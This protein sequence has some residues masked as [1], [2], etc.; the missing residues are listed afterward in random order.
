[1]VETHDPEAKPQYPPEFLAAIQPG[2]TLRINYGPEARPGKNTLR[3]VRGIVDDIVV[4]YRT[5]Q[6]PALGWSYTAEPRFSLFV[7]WN[8]GILTL[9]STGGNHE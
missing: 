8:M 1:M 9:A 4:V 7:E 3:H 6:G 2:N 5:W